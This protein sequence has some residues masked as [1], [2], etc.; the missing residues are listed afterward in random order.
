MGDQ[1][2]RFTMAAMLTAASLAL[3]ACGGATTQPTST[4][5][6][7]TA[8]TASA[9]VPDASMPSPSPT[10][11]PSMLPIT[12]DDLVDALPT[13]PMLSKVQGF[14]FEESKNWVEGGDEGPEWVAD[15]P[16]T[17][18]QKQNVRLA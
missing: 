11:T 18:E 12:S 13:N 5:P 15:A 2:T 7:T 3:V 16:L 8:P 9:V 6:S 4:T 10:P 1:M 17:K 14:T